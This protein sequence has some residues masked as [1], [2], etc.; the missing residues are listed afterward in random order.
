VRTLRNAAEVTREDLAAP[1]AKRE[2]QIADIEGGVVDATL[3]TSDDDEYFDVESDDDDATFVSRSAAEVPHVLA[4]MSCAMR[5]APL[6]DGGHIVVT[7]ITPLIKAKA[8]F[9][10]RADEI[11]VMPG[12]ARQ[13]ILVLDAGRRL[14]ASNG[15]A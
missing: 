3:A 2:P 15:I 14:I 11:A 8:D 4:S 5:T 10:Q 13:G 7:D 12:P 9:S 6:P 1:V